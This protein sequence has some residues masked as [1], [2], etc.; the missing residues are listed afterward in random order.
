MATF[1]LTINPGT[2]PIASDNSYNLQ[3]NSNQLLDVMSNDFLGEEPTTLVIIVV[4]T[5]GTAEVTTVAD[6]NQVIDYTCNSGVVGT[7][8]LY[9]RITDSTGAFDTG[10]VNITIG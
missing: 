6:G 7:D 10:V 9:Y 5:L 2:T 3:P 4:P 8:T 1:N